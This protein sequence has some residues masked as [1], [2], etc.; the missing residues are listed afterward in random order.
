MLCGYR[1]LEQKLCTGR[2]QQEG[3]TVVAN[4]LLGLEAI[5]GSVA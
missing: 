4:Y 5:E 2:A 3:P 1:I